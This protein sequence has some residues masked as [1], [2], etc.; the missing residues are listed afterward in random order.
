VTFLVGIVA[1][2]I[3]GAV[4]TGLRSKDGSSTELRR[5]RKTPHPALM[6]HI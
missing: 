3:V 6:A 1:K 2:V 5:R 4:Q